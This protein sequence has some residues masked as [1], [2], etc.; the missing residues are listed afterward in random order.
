M[1]DFECYSNNELIEMSL[2]SLSKHLGIN[3][4]PEVIKLNIARQAIPQYQIGHS[5]W[6]KQISEISHKII[7]LGNSLYG[8]SVNDCISRAKM[9]ADR[10]AK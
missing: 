3:V 1:P 4:L 9:A 2:Q 7:F 5:L 6:V 8:V 10:F